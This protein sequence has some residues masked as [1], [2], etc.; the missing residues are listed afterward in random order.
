VY[1]YTLSNV[2]LNA[3][4]LLHALRVLCLCLPPEEIKQVWTPLLESL[5]R[6]AETALA[7]DLERPPCPFSSLLLP[8]ADPAGLLPH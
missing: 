8:A 2:L 1:A 6:R 3:D 5:T 4:S 7:A